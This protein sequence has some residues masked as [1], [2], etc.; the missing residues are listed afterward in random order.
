MKYYPS[1]TT[2]YIEERKVGSNDKILLEN[3]TNKWA[4]IKPIPL[5]KSTVY[6]NGSRLNKGLSLLRLRHEGDEF[7][8]GY[9]DTFFDTDSSTK[10]V[11][12][13]MSTMTK[14]LQLCKNANS[15]RYSDQCG[16]ELYSYAKNLLLND[17]SNSVIYMYNHLSNKSID[18]SNID[19]VESTLHLWDSYIYEVNGSF[20]KSSSEDER[21]LWLSEDD[22]TYTSSDYLN[23]NGK[24]I[25][26]NTK[27]HIDIDVS[28]RVEKNA[29][30]RFY[31]IQR[32]LKSAKEISDLCLIDMNRGSD[33]LTNN[34]REML[35]TNAYSHDRLL[36]ELY[37]G[38][39]IHNE[40]TKG[41]D[42]RQFLWSYYRAL[43]KLKSIKMSQSLAMKMLYNFK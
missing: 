30:H 40:D 23:W 41:G 12:D 25:E 42:Y 27:T 36:M 37:Y 43:N 29:S 5:K 9:A 35:T 6:F 17:R 19:L 10:K 11:I 1:I 34:C 8:T 13:D 14:K 24:L 18:E 15:N 31:D 20:Y 38:A 26:Y 7:E 4:S 2:C 32:Y 33:R 28:K 39:M 16:I 21:I 22:Y 3:I